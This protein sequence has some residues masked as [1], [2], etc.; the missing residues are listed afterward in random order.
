[1]TTSL[2]E[3]EITGLLA[4][5]LENFFP[6]TDKEKSGLAGI[7]SIALKRC[8]HC[9]SHI[10]NKY[11][12]RD[13]QTFFSHLH[14]GQWM[15]FLCYAANTAS[16]GNNPDKTL[17]DKI[18]YLN[19]IMHSVDIYHEVRLPRVMFFEHPLG[20]VIGRAD[21]GD[22]LTVYQRCTIGGNIS[23]G[24][25]SYPV[26]GRN[27]TMYSDSK[28]IGDCKVGDNVTLAA[29]AYVKDTDLP[30]GS[31]VFGSSPNLTIKKLPS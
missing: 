9:F 29:N 1:M 26:I 14:S 30:S 2:S 31:T 25:I 27:F 22:G 28:I 6:L 7:V 4:K 23:R 21:I 19:K 20:T 3:N 11:F 15:T 8:E 18:Y 10:D 13:G 17:A 16:T 12:H 5:Q 24:K